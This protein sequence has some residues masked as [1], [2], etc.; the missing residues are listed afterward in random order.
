MFISFIAN[1]IFVTYQLRI[2]SKVKDILSLLFT[3][4]LVRVN[5]IFFKPRDFAFDSQREHHLIFIRFTLLRVNGF[6]S[7]VEGEYQPW[8]KRKIKLTIFLYLL[9][10]LS[11][12]LKNNRLAKIGVWACLFSLLLGSRFLDIFRSAMVWWCS[13][14]FI[15][16]FHSTIKNQW[17]RLLY[18]KKCVFQ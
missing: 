3:D 10:T 7:S 11:I 6:S 14:T 4:L 13:F 5:C 9:F 8:K 15:T 18:F 1:D 2:E 17:V 12:K 16:F